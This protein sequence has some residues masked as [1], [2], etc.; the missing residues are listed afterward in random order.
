MN[1]EVLFMSNFSETIGTIEIECPECGHNQSYK[2]ILFGGASEFGECMKC[3]SMT[4]NKP[5]GGISYG[6]T[7]AVECPYCHSKNTRKIS[8]MSKAGSVALFG[9]FSIGKVTKQW[10]CN[11]CKS[12]F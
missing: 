1:G 6:Q 9:I 11:D 4:Y 7:P 5:L 3:G 2:K 12:D 10:H 8:G